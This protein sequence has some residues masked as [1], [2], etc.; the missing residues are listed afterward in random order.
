M[1]LKWLEDGTA[2]DLVL[3]AE[4]SDGRILTAVAGSWTALDGQLDSSVG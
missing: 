1:N 3:T 2:I 4:L